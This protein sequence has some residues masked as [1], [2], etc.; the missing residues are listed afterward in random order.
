MIRARSTLALVTVALLCA[1]G[2]A[3]ADERTDCAAAYTQTQRLQLKSELIAA[4]DSAER[5]ARATCPALLKDECS[6]WA[7]EI[8]PKLPA[9]VVR[10]KASDGCTR[11][12][13]RIDVGQSRKDPDS[14]AI[15]VDPGVH[16]I[17][18]TD[19]VSG[20]E[21]TQ[22]INFAPGE[23]RD[24]DIEFAGPEVTCSKPVEV[25]PVVKTS[26]VPR[27]TLILGAIGG[28]MVLA[29]GTLGIVGALKRDDLDECKPACENDRIDGVR[30]FFV[31]G[32]V[33]AG[34]GVLVLGAAVV[35]FFGAEKDKPP[36]SRAT[37]T[38]TRWMLGPRGVG[39]TF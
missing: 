34:F 37:T 1:S 35:T 27:I 15:F 19:P 29:G 7:A 39:G 23:R 12:D 21:K 9:L 20:K 30:P 2:D 8:K 33:L 17:K 4:L 26:R 14:E 38:S 36:S 10:V 28:G 5:C 16:D 31:A 32:D 18:V 22:T 24:I 11:S 13:A 3:S 6:R 25:T